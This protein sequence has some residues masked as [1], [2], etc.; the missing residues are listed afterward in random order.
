MSLY[1]PPKKKIIMLSPLLDSTWK[2]A[3][4]RE[5]RLRID[6][7]INENHAIPVDLYLG[8]VIMFLSF[9][10][11]IVDTIIWRTSLYG[12]LIHLSN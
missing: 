10:A 5:N 4:F 11:G 2:F 8:I 12:E 9:N 3:K 1:K 6:R 7:E